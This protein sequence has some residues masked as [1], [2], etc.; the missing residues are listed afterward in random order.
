MQTKKASIGCCQV[1]SSGLCHLRFTFEAVS[2]LPLLYICPNPDCF[3]A[4]WLILLA[5]VSPPKNSFAASH[6]EWAKNLECHPDRKLVL[7]FPLAKTAHP[8]G[9]APQGGI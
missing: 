1:S 7:S 9:H 6:L 3:R 5:V 4:S 8:L 2:R